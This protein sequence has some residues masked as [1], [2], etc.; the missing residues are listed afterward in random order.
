MLPEITVR[1]PQGVLPR[2]TV[3]QRTVVEYQPSWLLLA[4]PV[5]SVLAARRRR[6]RAQISETQTRQRTGSEQT[7]PAPTSSA[8]SGPGAPVPEPRRRR[9]GLVVVRLTR[10]R[11][12]PG[13]PPVVEQADVV[14]PVQTDSTR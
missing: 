4:V 5:A 6:S 12:R 2:V 3:R 7:S 14:V 13:L 1:R 9:L 11:R 8:Q 10:L